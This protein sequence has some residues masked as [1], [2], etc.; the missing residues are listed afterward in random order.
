MGHCSCCWMHNVSNRLSCKP[1]VNNDIEVPD[2]TLV[3]M[4]D[5]AGVVSSQLDREKV[6]LYLFVSAW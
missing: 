1:W 4:L 5:S 6:F 2:W 3:F